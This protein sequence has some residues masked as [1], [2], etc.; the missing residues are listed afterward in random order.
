[1]SRESIINFLSVNE[2]VT[3]LDTESRHF[4]LP[5]TN[6]FPKLDSRVMREARNREQR[7]PS[8]LMS[9]G[10][11]IIGGQTSSLP[12]MTTD[13]MGVSVG[14]ATENVKRDRSETRARLGA[15]LGQLFSRMLGGHRAARL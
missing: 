3:N 6:P 15:G 7:L 10:A 11:V 8:V 13:I 14:Y 1:M 12:E 5:R 4:R 2:G 9:R